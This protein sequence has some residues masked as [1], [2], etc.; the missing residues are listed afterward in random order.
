MRRG[1]K[2]ATGSSELGA[3]EEVELAEIDIMLD[4]YPNAVHSYLYVAQEKGYFEEE[5]VKVNI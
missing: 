1:W 3:D 4:W 5:G 2:S